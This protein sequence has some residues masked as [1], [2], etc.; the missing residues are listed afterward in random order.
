M[1]FSALTIF[2]DFGCTK[3]LSHLNRFGGV[4]AD[5]SHGDSKIHLGDSQGVG[6]LLYS[7]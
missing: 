5:S 6:I 7:V 1:V 2:N 3:K 4:V